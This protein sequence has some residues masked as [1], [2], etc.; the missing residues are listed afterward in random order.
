[1]PLSAGTRIGSYEVVA[2]IGAGGRTLY[3]L[4]EPD[5]SAVVARFLFRGRTTVPRASV[6]RMD[7]VLNWTATLSSSR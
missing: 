6:T 5:G 4:R 2:L 1:M 3:Y 7:L